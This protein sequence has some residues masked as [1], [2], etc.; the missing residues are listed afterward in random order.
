MNADENARRF[1]RTAGVTLAAAALS[2]LAA[3][4]ALAQTGTLQD[5]AGPLALQP[6]STGIYTAREFITM[7]PS[8]PALK[9]SR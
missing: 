5:L 1:N 7:D 4:A 3:P 8:K 2:I 6:S 9:P